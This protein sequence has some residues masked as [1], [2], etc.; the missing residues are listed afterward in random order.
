MREMAAHSIYP[1]ITL[2]DT[3]SDIAASDTS[4]ASDDAR[5]GRN[6]ASDAV[7]QTSTSGN[8]AAPGPSTTQRRP[9]P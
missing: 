2:D 4:D 9:T 3:D 5:D 1:I 7:A 6:D 8:S